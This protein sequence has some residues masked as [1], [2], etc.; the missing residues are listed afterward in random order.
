MKDLSA[1]YISRR[2]L[3]HTA[4][5]IRR[6]HITVGFIGGSITE[7][8]S[9]KRWSEKVINWLVETFPG[10]AVDVENAAKGA[11]GTLSGIL[12]MDE[13]ILPRGCDL[14]FVESAVN[15]HEPAFGP[16]REG[17]L[18]RLL[19]ADAFDVVLTYTYHQSMYKDFL[20]GVLPPSIRDWEALAEHYRVSSVFMSRYAFDLTLQGCLRWEE[21]LPD[22][23]H[24][25]HAGSRL[26]AEPVCELLAGQIDTAA[27]ESIPLPAPLHPDHWENTHRLPWEAVTRHGACRLERFC[28]LPSVEQVMCTASMTSR[29]TFTFE[30]RG[31]IL[32]KTENA[33]CAGFRLLIDGEELMTDAGPIPDWG[34]DAADWVRE[35]TTGAVLPVGRH[36]AEL[37]PVFAEGRLGCQFELCDIGVIG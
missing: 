31:L 1:Y 25:A 5:A 20:D 26:Y 27:A 8:E 34:R 23:L 28:R 13:D 12:Y 2:A 14:V 22:G 37:I 18:R 17:E 4:Q 35:F 30:G 6:G 19:A 3:W 24:P 15:D 7:P 21:W 10:V 32:R 29:L 11:T 16:C 9:G 36:E 33:R